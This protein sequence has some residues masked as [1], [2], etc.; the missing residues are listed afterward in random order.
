MP[1]CAFL[2]DLTQLNSSEMAKVVNTFE[3][4]PVSK[5]YKLRVVNYSSEGTVSALAQFSSARTHNRFEIH[6]RIGSMY[7][8]LDIASLLALITQLYEGETAVTQGS[9]VIVFKS[10]IAHVLTILR[11]AC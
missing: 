1:F 6:A 3:N 8:L 4:H 5:Y 9:F 10:C 7:Y 11:Y 2:S